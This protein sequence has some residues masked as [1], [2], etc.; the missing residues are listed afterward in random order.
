M[1]TKYPWDFEGALFLV[2]SHDDQAPVFAPTRHRYLAFKREI[3]EKEGTP[4]YHI[5]LQTKNACKASTA[6]ASMGYKAHKPMK[7]KKGARGPPKMTYNCYITTPMD[8]DSYSAYI[9][10]PETSAGEYTQYGVFN[11]E[12]KSADPAAK[13][14][15][16]KWDEA[17]ERIQQGQSLDEIEK[18]DPAFFH[19]NLVKLKQSVGRQA[20]KSRKDWETKIIVFVGGGGTGKTHAAKCYMA[21]LGKPYYPKTGKTTEWNDYEGQEH[22]LWNDFIP[23]EMP[24]QHFFQLFDRERSSVRGLYQDMAWRCKCMVITVTWDRHPNNWWPEI[25]DRHQINRRISAI[26]TPDK[27]TVM[28]PLPKQDTEKFDNYAIA[29]AHFL[30]WEAIKNTA[31]ATTIIHYL[32]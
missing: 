3:G 20:K 8:V 19:M 30:V 6:L 25:E 26:Y 15:K 21:E 24:Y 16:R 1:A 10:K 7:R 4:H 12:S 18:W 28:W 13:G 5:L 14:K 32:Q 29:E 22:V 23:E 31:L 9:Q 11:G 17:A 27:Y 2:T